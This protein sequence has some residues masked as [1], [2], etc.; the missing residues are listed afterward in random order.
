MLE[1]HVVP[2]VKKWRV[3]CGMM[4]EQGAESLHAQ[5][6]TTERAYNNMRDRVQR[7]KVVLEAHHLSLLPTNLALE[8]PPLKKEKN[9]RHDSCAGCSPHQK[10]LVHR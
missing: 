10:T 8:P 9:S 1:D 4:G 7:L 5:F 2:W 3:G 6:N